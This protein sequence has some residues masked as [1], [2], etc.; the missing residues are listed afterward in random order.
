LTPLKRTVV[1]FRHLAHCND[2]TG[3]GPAQGAGDWEA[4]CAPALQATERNS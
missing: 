4:D 1:P 2:I 3:S